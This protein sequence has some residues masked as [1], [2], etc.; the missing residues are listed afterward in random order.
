MKYFILSIFILLSGCT[1]SYYVRNNSNVFLHINYIKHQNCVLR[2]DLLWISL[3]DKIDIW[4]Y[5]I[6]GSH[7]QNCYEKII[8]K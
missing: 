6:Y 7:I 2:N 8:E 4:Q 5:R 1:T 3:P